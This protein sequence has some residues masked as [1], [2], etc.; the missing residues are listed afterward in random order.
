M[1]KKKKKT[2]PIQRKL[3]EKKEDGGNMGRCEGR[4]GKDKTWGEV[5]APRQKRK[6]A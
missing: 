4:P 6:N 1:R 5:A 2:K 3:W